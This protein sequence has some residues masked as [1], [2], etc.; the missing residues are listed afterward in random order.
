MITLQS[1]IRP[2]TPEKASRLKVCVF[3]GHFTLHSSVQSLP[4][5]HG[6]PLCERSPHHPTLPRLLH[7]LHI[8]FCG[9]LPSHEMKDVANPLSPPQAVTW[10]HV[11]YHALPGRLCTDLVIWDRVSA[12]LFPRGHSIFFELDWYERLCKSSF[13]NV[14]VGT[15]KGEN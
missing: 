10:P 5:F 1:H 8:A 13:L 14:I 2:P 11:L 7:C 3:I 9:S 12:V 15:N 6:P 4:L